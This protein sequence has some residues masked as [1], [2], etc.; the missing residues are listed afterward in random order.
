[1]ILKF[2][3]LGR[4][5]TLKSSCDARLLKEVVQL[6]EEKI[7]EVRKELPRAATEELLIM[8]A[9]NL[10]FD[11]LEIKEDCRHFRMEVARRSEQLI[12]MLDHQSSLP[13]R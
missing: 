8:V 10:A 5:F 9:L 3:I 6:V 1:M 7:K 13:L 2:E 12:R 11:Y 4:P